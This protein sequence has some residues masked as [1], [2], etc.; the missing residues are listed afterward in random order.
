MPH[1][2]TLRERVKERK[3][4]EGGRWGKSWGCGIRGGCSSDNSEDVGCQI[5][6]KKEVNS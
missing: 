4:K 3:R 6:M 2:A 1:T 5:N